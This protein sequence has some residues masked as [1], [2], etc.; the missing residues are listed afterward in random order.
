MLGG[1]TLHQ[2]VTNAETYRL[3]KAS[4]SGFIIFLSIARNPEA[5][6]VDDIFLHN[7]LHVSKCHLATRERVL[8]EYLLVQAL[9]FKRRFCGVHFFQTLIPKAV[10]ANAHTSSSTAHSAGTAPRARVVELA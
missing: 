4:A 1:N 7:G 5:S 9:P 8:Q 2:S 3:Y 6:V 10:M